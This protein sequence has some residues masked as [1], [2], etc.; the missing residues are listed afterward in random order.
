MKNLILFL[1]IGT[2]FCFSSEYD[3]NEYSDGTKGVQSTVSNINHED[4][5]EDFVEPPQE[6]EHGYLWDPYTGKLVGNTKKISNLFIKDFGD[7]SCD[8]L[9]A[10]NVFYFHPWR[11]ANREDIK[12]VYEKSASS[13]FE[14]LCEV[15]SFREDDLQNI[16]FV[17]FH[18]PKFLADSVRGFNTFCKN[19]NI[20]IPEID[21]DNPN[22]HSKM[23]FIYDKKTLTEYVDIIKKA[24]IFSDLSDKEKDGYIFFLFESEIIGDE[25]W[26]AKI[27]EVMESF[28]TVFDEWIGFE[29]RR[30]IISQFAL[31]GF[32]GAESIKNILIH[33]KNGYDD[34]GYSLADIIK[35]LEK[36]GFSSG[37]NFDL[38]LVLIGEIMATAS[39]HVTCDSILSS[40]M[41]IVLDCNMDLKSLTEFIRVFIKNDVELWGSNVSTEDFVRMAFSKGFGNPEPLDDFIKTVKKCLD[42]GTI[43][44]NDQPSFGIMEVLNLYLESNLTKESDIES[45]YKTY[46]DCIEPYSYN[47]LIEEVIGNNI[48]KSGKLRALNSAFSTLR[49]NNC[50]TGDYIDTEIPSIV[51]NLY[52][53]KFYE[54]EGIKSLC[55]IFQN[56]EFSIHDFLQ[57][58]SENQFNDAK[59]LSLISQI[60]HIAIELDSSDKYIPNSVLEA[61]MTHELLSEDKLENLLN[62]IKQKQFE[63]LYDLIG[64][65]NNSEYSEEEEGYDIF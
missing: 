49:E 52:L 53:A 34:T 44:D 16:R 8:V 3:E 59:C 54:P 42:N 29:D 30:K 24:K 57:L 10:K 51:E 60:I 41:K 17:S 23:P 15:K 7:L 36:W 6:D 40:C 20:W 5:E 37:K 58:C 31:S 26:Q 2:S 43:P 11:W 56:N 25:D 63:D 38:I 19:N 32:Y 61:C 4:W 47:S 50:L 13:L 35:P 9:S 12:L 55:S 27:K 45:V 62:N 65:I 22:S 39:S 46:F 64:C 1:F 48:A 21:L 28:A 18:W 14:S 33:T